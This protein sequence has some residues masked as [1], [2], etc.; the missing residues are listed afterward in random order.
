MHICIAFLG[1]LM[2]ATDNKT[3]KVIAIPAESIETKP[4]YRVGNATV[5]INLLKSFTGLSYIFPGDRV[6]KRRMS[7]LRL[8]GC[9]IFSIH[10][11]KMYRE[12]A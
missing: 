12:A 3:E 11:S 4:R 7:F 5:T 6:W 9:K 8:Q 10:A 1:I 2:E